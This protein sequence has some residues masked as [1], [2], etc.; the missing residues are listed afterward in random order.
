MG[1]VLVATRQHPQHGSMRH[2]HFDERSSVSVFRKGFPYTKDN[3]ATLPKG[4][5][6]H[7]SFHPCHVVPVFPNI[8]PCAW[9]MNNDT[10]NKP[11]FFPS[12]FVVFSDL[13]KFI[14]ATFGT[15]SCFFSICVAD[16]LTEAETS[17]SWVCNSCFNSVISLSNATGRM[18]NPEYV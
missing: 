7:R 18:V 15:S 10:K 1:Q 9:T 13:Y 8:I 5:T 3:G 2:V 14:N 16:P 11:L 12:L 4:H 6:E 17:P